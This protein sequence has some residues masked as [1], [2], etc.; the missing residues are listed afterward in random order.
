MGEVYKLAPAWSVAEQIRQVFDHWRVTL[1]HARAR[2]DA[3]RS[4]T[5]RAMLEAGY[6]VD[7]LKLAIDGC[8]C[9]DWHRGKNDRSTVYDGL[10]L[11]CRDAEHVDR[12]MEIGERAR[13]RN[14][15]KRELEAWQ[16]ANRD[17]P[18]QP[19]RPM[20]EHLKR[21]VRAYLGKKNDEETP[22]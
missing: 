14:S 4:R 21:T 17:A 3:T 6:S 11:I 22:Q 19:K 18:R 2:L 15:A 13:A 5:V 16:K 12:F 9:S 20:P 7:D 8:A 10:G 1:G